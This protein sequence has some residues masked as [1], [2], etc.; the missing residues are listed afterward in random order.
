M[1]DL[2]GLKIEPQIF[3]FVAK[4]RTK[5]ILVVPPQIEQRFTL[6]GEGRM[7]KKWESFYEG[8]RKKM[9]KEARGD[10]VKQLQ[11]EQ[12]KLKKDGLDLENQAQDSKVGGWFSSLAAIW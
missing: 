11:A 2:T 7:A 10:E 1:L 6:T 9:C 12:E 4:T 5:V 3:F 8:E